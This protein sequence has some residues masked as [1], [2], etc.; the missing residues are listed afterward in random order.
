M[1]ND[2]DPR[3][4][5]YRPDLADRRLAGRVAAGR[6]VEG[7]ER[8]VIATTAV[9]RRRPEPDLGADTEALFG[10]RL[11]VFEETPEGWAWVQLD[12]DGY[13]GWM[14]SAALAV[15]GPAANRKVAVLRT[16]R[17]PRP[18]MKSPPLGHL[19][20]SSRVAVADIDGKFARLADGSFVI[21]RHLGEIDAVEA[22]FVAVAERFLGVPYLWG[23]K[24]SLGLDCSGLVQIALHAAGLCCPRD[25]DMQAAEAGAA[26]DISGGLPAFRRG[27]LVFW[28]GHVGIMRS[29]TELLHANAFHM[30]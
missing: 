9:L 3:R 26:L 8:Q 7:A 27:D 21:A 28:R 17:Y 1:T 6:F 25:S 30:L 16:F 5:A 23:G 19:A 12:E 29:E 22:D 24:S 18:D 2:L 13:V 20:F 11:R 10:E 15:A 14:A 4:H